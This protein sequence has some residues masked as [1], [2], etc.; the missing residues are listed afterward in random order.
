VLAE[1]D[2]ERIVEQALGLEPS[3]V[4]V[5]S[6]QT[7]SLDGL[8]GPAGSVG[9]VRESAARLVTYARASQTPVVLVGQ[10]T[11]DGSLAGPKTL[12]H[13][14]DA[15]LALEGERYGT[16][17]VLRAQKNR[18]GSTEEI[19]VFEMVAGGL[20][21]MP[22]AALAFLARPGP[23]AGT[24]ASGSVVA[25]T[26]EGSRPL[27]VEV[28]ALVAPT[29]GVNPRRTANGP[30]PARLALIVAVLG[31]RAGVI[32]GADD[33]YASLAGGLSVAEPALDLPLALA[34]ASSKRDRPVDPAIVACG[35]IGLLGELR[36]VTGLDRRLREAARLGFRRAIVPAAGPAPD[37]AQLGDL[38]MVRAATLREAVAIALEARAA[39]AGPLGSVGEPVME[40]RR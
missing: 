2:V 12:E 40:G 14:V 10:V 19:G 27:L 9:Q 37:P 39:P 36:P 33:L 22:D 1:T 5:D 28:Q 6:V 16:I 35:E 31:R 7:I 18:F 32:V 4:I 21:P 23:D 20:R 38:A 24:R 26:L 34:I 15:V 3:L 13:L 11:K 29:H 25:A 30:D 17:R 8:E